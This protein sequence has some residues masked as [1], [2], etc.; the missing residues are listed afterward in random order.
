MG[1]MDGQLRLHG[2]ASCRAGV[3]G[4]DKTSETHASVS[5]TQAWA[6]ASGRCCL[7]VHQR[8]VLG[9]YAVACGP[10]LQGVLDGCTVA[11]GGDV[12]AWR[13]LL[14]GWRDCLKQGFVIH[15]VNRPTVI[16]L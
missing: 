12:V 1:W 4:F 5:A 15:M 2:D 7:G 13:R 14:A 16:G 10:P 8:Q 9:G 6:A 11:R 3:P